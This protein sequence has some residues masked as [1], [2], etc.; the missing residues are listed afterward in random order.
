M[1]FAPLRRGVRVRMIS[2]E[3][4]IQFGYEAEFV[5][6]VDE[7]LICS[8]CK[9]PLRMPKLTRCGHRFCKGCLDELLRQNS[10]DQR[11]SC[12]QCRT[13]Q[14][15]VEDVFPDNATQRKVLSL[16]V[17]CPNKNCKWTGELRSKEKHLGSCPEKVVECTSK[18][19]TEKMPLKDL[20]NHL[21][22]CQWRL[23]RCAHCGM[24]HP[25]C[26]LSKHQLECKRFPV[27]CPK[28][29]GKKFPREET[30]EHLRCCPEEIV[31]C[32]NTNCTETM[33]RKNLEEHVTTTCQWRKVRCEHCS[34]QHPAC[35]QSEH[36]R[37]CKRFPVKCRMICGKVMPREEIINH[38]AICPEEIVDCS[39]DG[40]RAIMARKELEEHVTTRCRWRK[41]RC[42]H[43]SIQHPACLKSDHQ[44]NCTRFPVNCSYNCGEEFPREELEAHIDTVCPMAIVPCPFAEMDCQ[45]KVRR[46][47]LGSHVQ[48]ATSAHLDLARV[49]LTKTHEEHKELKQWTRHLEAKLDNTLKEV[50]ELKKT[51][52]KLEEKLKYTDYEK[53]E[54]KVDCI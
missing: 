27:N 21:T 26:Q 14:S 45:T 52:R 20:E 35:K 5:N 19:C 12:P 29:C 22:T 15:R 39:S 4:P 10:G 51:T 43:C 38:S 25:A 2:N 18:N 41:L 11:F 36:Q 33:A 28:R 17:K 40:C 34:I 53:L 8:I 1:N 37:E 13:G 23:I 30:Q 47:E 9:L 6:V 50:K 16:V 3:N 32:T 7:D 54:E 24:Q 42:E 49:K 44:L 31:K 48:T 46:S